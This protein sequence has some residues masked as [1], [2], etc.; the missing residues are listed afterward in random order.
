MRTIQ[1]VVVMCIQFTPLGMG[2]KTAN[3]NNH[4]MLQE[5]QSLTRCKLANALIANREDFK[6][7]VF[8]SSEDVL[9]DSH[10]AASMASP[11]D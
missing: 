6:D 3:A 4:S 1:L 11:I 9:T 10:E 7:W 8:T 2:Q 5:D